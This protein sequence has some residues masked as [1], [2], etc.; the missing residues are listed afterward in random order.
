MHPN[1][2]A[3]TYCAHILSVISPLNSTSPPIAPSPQGVSWKKT[4][5]VF[6]PLAMVTEAIYDE[7]TLENVNKTGTDIRLA[8]SLKLL[9]PVVSIVNHYC[10]VTRR[11]AVSRS[12][13]PMALNGVSSRRSRSRLP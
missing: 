13:L 5:V 4:T 11:V 7:P 6:A 12:R 2:E 9:R 8:A 3:C 1:F 10:G